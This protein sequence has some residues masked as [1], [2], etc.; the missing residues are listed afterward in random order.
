MILL[1]T[2]SA[3]SVL[4]LIPP[5]RTPCSVQWLAVSICLCI[6]QALAGP[7]RRQLYQ[8]PFIKHFLASAIVSG[9]GSVYGMDTQVRKSLDGLSFR[10]CSTLCPCISFRQ[11]S[12]WIKNLEMIRWPHPSKEVLPNLWIWT[13]QELPPLCWHLN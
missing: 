9:F 12:L 13:L 8:A 7:L 11:E 5:L 1:Q 2:P 6:C 3:P 4:S 10:F